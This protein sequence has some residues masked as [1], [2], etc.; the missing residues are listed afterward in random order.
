MSVRLLRGLREQ[1]GP[2]TAGE[3]HE[4]AGEGEQEESDHNDDLHVD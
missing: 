1:H 4:R 3:L 2:L